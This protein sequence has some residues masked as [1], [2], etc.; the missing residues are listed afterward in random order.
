MKQIGYLL[1]AL[2][3]CMLWISTAQASQ[4]NPWRPQPQQWGNQHRQGDNGLETRQTMGV[5][6]QQ[7]YSAPLNRIPARQFE[8]R[9]YMQQV[10]PYY[11]NQM[12]WWSDPVAVP[13]GPWSTGNDGSNGFW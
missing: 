11:S 9:H 5:K 2:L 1:I 4:Y 13:Y 8:Y 10:S 7:H 12:P 3:P 6:P